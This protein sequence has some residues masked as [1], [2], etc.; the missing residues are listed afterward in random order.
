VPGLVPVHLPG[1]LTEP[2][3]HLSGSPERHPCCHRSRFSFA[4]RYVAVGANGSNLRDT[5]WKINAAGESAVNGA[6][7]LIP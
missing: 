2:A 4:T 7:I 5:D 3:V 6:R 1:P